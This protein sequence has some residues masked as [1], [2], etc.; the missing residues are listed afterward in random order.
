MLVPAQR[1]PAESRWEVYIVRCADGSLYTGIARDAARRVAEHNA[2]GRRA[3]RYTRGRRPVELVYRE[4]AATR[5]AAGQREFQIKRMSR[6]QKLALI[7]TAGAAPAAS[8]RRST[9]RSAS[10]PRSA[11]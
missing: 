10:L 7:L 1:V 3:A 11:V 4:P 6:G 2:P 8:L 9:P 5:S